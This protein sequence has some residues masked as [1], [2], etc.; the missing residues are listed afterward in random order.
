[1]KRESHQYGYY[2]RRKTTRHAACSWLKAGSGAELR[3]IR[4]KT[5]KYEEKYK[6]GV[7]GREGHAYNS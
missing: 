1:M 6:K 5:K 7:D 4:R 2:N 3:D